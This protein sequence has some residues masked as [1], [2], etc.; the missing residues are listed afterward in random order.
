M[1]ES[2]PTWVRKFGLFGVVVVDLLGYSVAGFGLGYLAWQKLG[3]PWWIL[4][5]TCPAGLILA[6]WKIYQLYQSDL[7]QDLKEEKEEK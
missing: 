7:A 4:L 6:F 2:Q 3:W 1:A 5:I